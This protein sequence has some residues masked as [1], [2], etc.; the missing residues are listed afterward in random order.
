MKFELIKNERGVVITNAAL[1]LSSIVN[2]GQYEMFTAPNALVVTAKRMTAKE[3][4]AAIV[5]LR[6]LAGEM[7]MELAESC[8][9][10]CAECDDNCIEA[11]LANGVDTSCMEYASKFKPFGVTQAANAHNIVE[12]TY[13]EFIARGYCVR[14]LFEHYVNGDIVYGK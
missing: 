5:S 11:M 12:A 10:L 1:A 9:D 14:S 13:D 8:K 4:F 2:A 3:L 6:L 7:L